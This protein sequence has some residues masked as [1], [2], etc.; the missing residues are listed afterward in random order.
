MV[1][2]DW[3]VL[4][5]GRDAGPGAVLTLGQGE[6]EFSLAGASRKVPAI[7]VRLDLD[8]SHPVFAE[9]EGPGETRENRLSLTLN[10]EFIYGAAPPVKTRAEA[11]AVFPRIEAPVFTITA[12][13]VQ[14]AELINTRFKVSLRV[15]N[16]NSFPVE[17]SSFNYKLYG[18]GRL[19][20]DGKETEVLLVPPK[21]SAETSLFLVMNFI[22]MRRELLD[23]IIAMKQINYRFTGEALVST[24]ISYLPQFRTTFDRS[25]FSEVIE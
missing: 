5:N 13:A 4:M 11:E 25:G 16:P 1:A 17:L 14:K 6:G 9:P 24:G 19:W 20:A 3:Q 8:L 7:P 23:Q 18:S 2:G 12:I 21:D 22:N 15:D 10:P